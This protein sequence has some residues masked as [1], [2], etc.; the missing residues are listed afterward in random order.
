MPPI[1]H[2]FRIVLFSLFIDTLF[3]IEHSED[4]FWKLSP[5]YLSGI[6]W[7]HSVFQ[8]ICRRF[9]FFTHSRKKNKLKRS[10]KIFTLYFAFCTKLCNCIFVIFIYLR[11]LLDN[12][13][14]VILKVYS[15]KHKNMPI[16]LHSQSVQQIFLYIVLGMLR[17]MC[18]WNGSSIKY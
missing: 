9:Y 7:L 8:C 4:M 15:S 12:I 18:S 5:L 13:T 10:L 11:N 16:W 6:K 3:A 2:F 1:Y 14:N 17:N